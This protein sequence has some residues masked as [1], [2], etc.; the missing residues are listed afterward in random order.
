MAMTRWDRD[1][2][3]FQNRLGRL[4]DDALRGD[5]EPEDAWGMAEWAPPVDIFEQDGSLVLKAELPGVRAE[6]VQVHLENSVLTIRG[7]RRTEQEVK[8]ENYHR[9][10]RAYG[11]FVRSFT[12]SPQ[13]DQD[14]IEASFA[15]GILRLTVP[16]S[17]KARP[18]QIPIG[19]TS[20]QVASQ[21]S[22]SAPAKVKDKAAKRTE[23]EE[24]VAVT[25]G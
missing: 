15:D 7:E 23:E 11:T 2:N 5:R 1:L 12:L 25:R 19:A 20:S 10:E 3:R 6:D 21:S 22:A 16:R 13:Y 18:R 9:M 8:R 14:K 4:F 17:E 24:E